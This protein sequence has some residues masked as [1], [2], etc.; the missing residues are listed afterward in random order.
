MT[1]SQNSKTVEFLT[2]IIEN[3][4]SDKDAI[5]ITR[6][7][8]EMGVLLS[9]YVAPDDRGKVIG[10]KGAIAKAIRTL[11]RAVGMGTHERVTLRILEEHEA[12]S[13]GEPKAMQNYSA[14]ADSVGSIIDELKDG[15]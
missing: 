6:T 13:A 7:V 15:E 2:Y 14:P 4:V 3:L 5:K 9:L 11:L 1:D 12:N 8:D 10:K